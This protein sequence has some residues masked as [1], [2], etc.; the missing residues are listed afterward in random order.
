MDIYWL[1][2]L[3]EGEGSFCK[4]PPSQPYAPIISIEMTDK[5]VVER[6]AGMFQTA[7]VTPKKRSKKWKQTYRAAIRGK[8]A[9]ELMK[10]L[11]PLMGQRRQ[12]QIDEVLKSFKPDENHWTM[13]QSRW[14][15]DEK[16]KE[17]AKTRSLRS[18]GEEL[19]Y[20]HQAVAKRLALLSLG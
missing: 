9:V 15:D 10:Q 2:G 12:G 11:H 19:G 7:L 13:K 1:A 17:M 8:R 4:A 14:P 3:L 20:S 6:V 16:L 5:D 18:I